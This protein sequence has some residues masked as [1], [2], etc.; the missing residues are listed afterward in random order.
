MSGISISRI[1]GKAHH[2]ENIQARLQDV[3]I[4]PELLRRADRP[5]KSFAGT[6]ALEEIAAMTPQGSEAIL[7]ALCRICVQLCDCGSSGVNL[8]EKGE[9]GG[10]FRWI[11]IEGTL[12]PYQGYIAPGDHSPCGFVCEQKSPQLLSHSARYFEWIQAVDLPI[13]ESLI[14][15]LYRDKDEIIGTMW[16]VSHDEDR[17]FDREDLRVLT[18][19]GSHAAAALKLYESMYQ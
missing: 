18:M 17:R 19:L 13:V 7:Q 6:L 14:A 8:L 3:V 11:V 12:K 2:M 16:L 5:A 1:G 4:T 15:P 10:H 9:D